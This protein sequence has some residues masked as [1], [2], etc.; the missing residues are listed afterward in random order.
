M[1]DSCCNSYIFNRRVRNLVE[2]TKIGGSVLIMAILGGS[3][4]TA[5]QDQVSDL[6]GSIN[7][8]YS[9]SLVCF[10]FIAYYAAVASLK[11]IV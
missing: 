6:T 2:D 11:D 1:A 5:I 8:A 7:I 4:I 10:L 3:V 9:I